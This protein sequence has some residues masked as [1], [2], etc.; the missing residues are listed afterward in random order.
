MNPAAP[1]PAQRSG[2]AVASLVLGLVGIVLCLGP[3]AGIPAVICGHMAHSQ[4]RKS[5]GTIGGDG[6]ATAGLVTGYIS[7]VLVFVIGLLAAIAIPNFVK[8]RNQAMINACR[9]NQRS[10]EAA[11]SV[12]VLDQAK[13][14]D[15]APSDDDLFGPGKYMNERPVCPAGGSYQLNDGATPPACS[16]HGPLL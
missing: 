11:K 1:L 13:K 12:W 14:K 16:V 10:I 8:A 4:I 6:M 2:L 7:I 3:L 15:V 5:G 9:D